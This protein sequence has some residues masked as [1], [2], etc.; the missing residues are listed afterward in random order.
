MEGGLHI[1]ISTNM[2]V[3]MRTSID[4]PDALFSRLKKLARAR[5][6]T[7]RE[8]TIEGLHHVLERAERPKSFRLRDGSFGEGGLT[9]GLTETE[10]QRIR[11]ISYEGRGG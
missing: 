5:G 2:L 7:L 1:H 4:L 8:L 6:T 11:D 3:H 10:W 9:G